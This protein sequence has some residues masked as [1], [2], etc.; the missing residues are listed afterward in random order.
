MNFS[1]EKRKVIGLKPDFDTVRN[2]ILRLN[3]FFFLPGSED[4]HILE[5]NFGHQL[6]T[7]VLNALTE[8]W[9]TEI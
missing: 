6:A 9:V 5:E 7:Y 3:Q 4:V 8:P 1:T 2:E